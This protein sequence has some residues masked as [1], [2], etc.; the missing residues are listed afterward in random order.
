M[1]VPTVG[2]QKIVVSDLTLAYGNS[3]VLRNIEFTVERGEIFVIMGVN[4]SGK[5]TLLKFLIGLLPPVKG[6]VYYDGTPFWGSEATLKNRILR[7]IGILYQRNALWSSMTLAENVALP[8]E[9]HTNLGPAEIREIVSFKLSLVGLKGFGRY[10][11]SELSGGMQKRAALARAMA[12]D[13]EILFFDEPS[14]GLDPVNA[15]LLDDLILDLNHSLRTT[16]VVIS[17]D[18]ESIFTIADTSIFLDPEE[19]TIVA[20][21]NPEW[22]LHNSRNEKV[23]VFLTRGREETQ[24]RGF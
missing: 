10:F 3:V 1:R 5:S 7:G 2:D 6:Q 17:H 23:R 14:S 4:G 18:L 11:P 20:S 9:E 8:L 15:G 12:L 24:G 19:K 13:P 16:I 22:L 21:G